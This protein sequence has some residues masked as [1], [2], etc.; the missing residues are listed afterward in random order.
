MA[1]E[2]EIRTGVKRLRESTG[3]GGDL[4]RALDNVS[5]V[6]G[7]NVFQ[8]GAN[9]TAESPEQRRKQ[10]VR[11]RQARELR[12]SQAV[13]YCQDCTNDMNIG[14]AGNFHPCPNL[15]CP[16]PATEAHDNI[17]RV[18]RSMSLSSMRARPAPRFLPRRPRRNRAA[19]ETETTTTTSTEHSPASTTTPLSRPM[20]ARPAGAKR[21][22]NC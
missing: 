9:N 12:A 19:A 17:R 7:D 2:A 16:C 8:Q 3:T 1:E 10:A 20:G 4:S 11:D 15:N 22:R 14:V 13:V 21:G 5:D 6:D 18:T